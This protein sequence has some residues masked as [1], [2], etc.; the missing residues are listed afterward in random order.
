MQGRGHS[1]RRHAECLRDRLV[2]EVCVV[3]KEEGE[4]LPL[5]QARDERFERT[6]LAVPVRGRS[7][8]R[9]CA[10]AGPPLSGLSPARLVDHDPEE[11]ALARAAPVESTP[12]SQRPHERVVD[13]LLGKL[14]VAQD[15]G[16]DSQESAVTVPVDALDLI[17]VAY[18][19]LLSLYDPVRSSFL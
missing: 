14:L 6:L 15:R 9:Q 2:V 5:R 3:T 17:L 16:G 11:P 18:L 1:A 12:V 13:G 7:G 8:L 19:D 10:R 4:S